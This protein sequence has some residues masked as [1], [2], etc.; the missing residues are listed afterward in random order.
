MT[1]PTALT[2]RAALLDRLERLST[3]GQRTAIKQALHDTG[4]TMDSEDPG[5]NGFGLHLMGVYAVGTCMG[6]AVHHW[7]CTTRT[8][9][10]GWTEPSPDPTLH[11]A[12]I[13]WAAWVLARQATCRTVTTAHLTA[14][15]QIVLALS[16]NETLRTHAHQLLR[17]YSPE[18]TNAHGE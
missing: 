7:I 13:A 6:D 9:H 3:D 8:L 17:S 5:R 18:R 16:V 2:D 11:G 12:Q 4:G 10:G 15:C 14:A 1:S